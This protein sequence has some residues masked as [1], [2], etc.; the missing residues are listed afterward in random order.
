MEENNTSRFV[1]Y[2]LIQKELDGVISD[3]ERMLLEHWLFENPENQNLYDTVRF[4][5]SDL[6]VFRAV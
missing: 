6:T 1:P 5:Y 2:G 3:Q 4:I